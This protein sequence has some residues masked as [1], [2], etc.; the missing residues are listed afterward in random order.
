MRL[1]SAF[2]ADS[3]AKEGGEGDQEVAARDAGQVEE[4]VRDLAE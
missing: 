4:G 1:N 3:G 2:A